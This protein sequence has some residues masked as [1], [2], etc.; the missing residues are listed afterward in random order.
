VDD[1]ATAE[2]MGQFYRNMFEEH[3]RPA[4]ALRASQL[5]LWRQPRWH[6]PYF[7]AAFQLQ[8]EWN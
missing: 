5:H 7:W 1:A 8:G 2:L 3:L 4:A 6:D